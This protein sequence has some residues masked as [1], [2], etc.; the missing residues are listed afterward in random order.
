MKMVGCHLGRTQSRPPI[1]SFSFLFGLTMRRSFKAHSRV[2]LRPPIFRSSFLNFADSTLASFVAPIPQL[3]R[4]K[5]SF[6]F[7]FGAI[8]FILPA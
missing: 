8:K 2:L 7:S 1:F 5:S 4:E 3:H 6:F